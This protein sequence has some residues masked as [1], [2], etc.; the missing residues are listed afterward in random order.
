MGERM[1]EHM[2]ERMRERV[3]FLFLA[4]LLV[5]A[6]PAAGQGT[7]IW[8]DAYYQAA[9]V[10]AAGSPLTSL[11]V[12]QEGGLSLN[13][14]S[15]TGLEFLADFVV[16]LEIDRELSPGALVP[17]LFVRASPAPGVSISA[18][19]QRLNWGTA[20]VFAPIDLLETRTNPL[21]LR[22]RLAGVSGVKVDIFPD[23]LFGVSLAALPASDLRWSRAAAKVELL[24]ENEGI[25]VGLGIV[26]YGDAD[27]SDRVGFTSDAAWTL[28]PVVIYDEVQLRWGSESGYQFPGMPGLEDRGGGNEPVL[29]GAAGLMFSVDLGL[30]RP[31]GVLVEYFYN[32]DGLTDAEA[33]LF[34][35]RYAAW[36]AAGYPDGAVLPAAFAALGG[37]RRHYAAVA[38]RDIALDRLLLLGVTGIVG[39]DSLL[40]WLA[41]DLE[42]K[43]TQGTSFG[44]RCELGHAFQADAPTDLL[45]V[46][47]RN[48]LTLSVTTSYR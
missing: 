11:G 10:D 39:I 1:R 26:K 22:P 5:L 40:G 13:V 20:K 8:G 6:R 35:S 14:R 48:R 21:D 19:R 7:E 42:W 29:R 3:P 23:D 44:L 25:D 41:V 17:Q 32:G 36:Q 43:V 12:A 47:F 4:A 45:L 9:A 38:L 16:P 33:R 2:G 15:A 37:L 30:T 18:G 28:G 27:S 24:S 31:A 46:P 34:A